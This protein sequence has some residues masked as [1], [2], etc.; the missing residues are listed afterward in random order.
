MKCIFGG[1]EYFL[2]G[3]LPTS[4]LASSLIRKRI[5]SDA[6][7]VDLGR[8]PSCEFFTISIEKWRVALGVRFHIGPS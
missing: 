6:S 4:L 1:K 2:F 8:E 3:S 5:T 7:P